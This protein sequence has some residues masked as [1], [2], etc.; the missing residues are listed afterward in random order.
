MR[1]AVTIAALGFGVA[2]AGDACHVASGAT[3]YEWD[4]VPEIWRSQV[5]FPFLVA[6]FLSS[7]LS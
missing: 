2:L 4:G 5:W 7:V 6:G 3:R 1:P